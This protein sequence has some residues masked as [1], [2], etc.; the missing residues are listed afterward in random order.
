M[1]PTLGLRDPDRTVVERW[2]W[3]AV[4]ANGF[5][6]LTGGL[7]R[8]TGSGLGCP[9]WPKCTDESFVP[10]RE[11]GMHG[12]IEFGNRLL[13]YVLIAIVVATFVAVW[14]WS[15]T[16]RRLRQLAA[17]IALGVP[18]QGVI[19]GIT[20][21]TDLNPWV[22]SLHL[23][24]SMLLVAA[25]MLLVFRVRGEDRVGTRRPLVMLTYLVSWVVVYLGTVVTG[26]GPHAGDDE[27]PRNMLDP[28]LMS[29]V[30]AWSVY[31]LVGLTLL[32]IW[33]ES[34]RVR[35][36]AVVLL[37]VEL[38]QGLIGFV[39]YF[40]DLPITLVAAHLVGAAVLMAAATRLL[41]TPDRAP[42]PASAPS[43]D[44]RV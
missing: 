16:S 44:V 12:L 13:T 17:L 19:G 33:K 26:S 28:R 18:F 7:V 27:S 29:H 31:V 11:L 8:L 2:A 15:G 32:V 36:A 35:A 6:I 43:H 42:S 4:V 40:N 20:V 1:A 39:Q 21:L 38:A 14:R 22:V 5:I 30:H 3:A 24:L 37:V 25:S 23:L 41:L 10:H 9:T 34:G